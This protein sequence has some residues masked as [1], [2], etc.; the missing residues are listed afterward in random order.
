MIAEAQESLISDLEEAVKAGS[1]EKRIQTLRHVTDLFLNDA[2][3]FSEDQIAVFDDVLC[4]LINR[5][6]TKAKA[7]LGERL[8]PIDNAP[9]DVIQKLARDNE[10]S[11][12]GPVLTTSK[13]LSD[14]DLV[15]IAKSKGQD[16]LFAIS[17]RNE[18]S[19]A[20][21]DVI[22]DRG[23]QRVVNRLA[24]NAGAKFSESGFSN[25]VARAEKDGA[26]AESMSLRMDLPIKF[27][28]ELLS[29]ATDAVRERLMALA[30]PELQEQI[31]KTLQDIANAVGFEAAMPRN[32]TAAE[33]LVRSMQARNQLDDQAL[34]NFAVTHK[35]EE[36]TA[37]L[38]L[39]AGIS[40]D[41]IAKLMQSPR[42]D[43]LLI[44]CKAALLMWP[45]V[46]AILRN[47]H[48]NRTVSEDIIAL[49]M[50]DYSRLTKETAQ[51]T[52]RF[53]SVRDKVH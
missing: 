34:M 29:R 40:T 49:A 20:V 25:L 50:R 22:V 5:I 19:T 38:A 24:G 28:R 32:F 15:E 8:A 7:E 45:A 23:E 2:D 39:M 41:M 35:I 27:L 17:G 10:I 31:R 42:N 1:P 21:T 37:G 30:P 46:E 9:V 53:W 44:P 14:S 4:L 47:R 13:R 26:L 6:E 51:R 3:K 11:V 12:A 16:H 33:Q 48:A 43:A 36:V 18:L 52:L